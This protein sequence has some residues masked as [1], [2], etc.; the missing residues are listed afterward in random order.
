MIYVNGKSED[1]SRLGAFSDIV[2]IPYSAANQDRNGPSRIQ[3]PQQD[4]NERIS[5]V[6]SSK[7]SSVTKCFISFEG[8]YYA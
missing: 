8:H 7:E 4:I 1:L 6:L 5:C 2:D 3:I